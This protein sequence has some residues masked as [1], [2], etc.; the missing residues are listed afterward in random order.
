MQRPTSATHHVHV[1]VGI[2][3][4]V[5]DRFRQTSRE[6]H[7]KI[8][9]YSIF[10]RYD[11]FFSGLP[12]SFSSP[13]PCRIKLSELDCTNIAFCLH[14]S[15]ETIM[16]QLSF[17][18]WLGKLVGDNESTRVA[19]T[20]V[21]VLACTLMR[22]KWNPWTR[23]LFISIKWSLLIVHCQPPPMDEN[24]SQFL[25]FFLLLVQMKGTSTS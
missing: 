14:T 23:Q 16:W 21:A 11:L 25:Y 5:F 3:K 6:A 10:S 4:K 19:N 1:Q 24:N 8:V 17:R 22:M 20:E 13:D 7:K 2:H 15:R 12:N 9:N 18:V